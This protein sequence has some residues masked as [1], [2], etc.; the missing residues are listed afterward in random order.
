MP[1]LGLTLTFI[2]WRHALNAFLGFFHQYGNICRNVLIFIGMHIFS[3]SPVI[4]C[5]W[6]Q[7]K[8]NAAKELTLQILHT[9]F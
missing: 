3:K 9:L 7:G 1:V 4:P 6:G 8:F 2:R 5:T